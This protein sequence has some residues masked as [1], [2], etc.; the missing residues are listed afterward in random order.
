VESEQDLIFLTIATVPLDAKRLSINIK[1]P[2]ALNPAR[3]IGRQVI[4]L[5]EDYSVKYYPFLQAGV[6]D[7]IPPDEREG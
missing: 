7:A 3:M 2:V 1:S 4:L 6:G 5:N